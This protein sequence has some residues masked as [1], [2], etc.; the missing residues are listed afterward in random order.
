MHVQFPAQEFLRKISGSHRW[1]YGQGKMIESL[2]KKYN[3][4]L[5]AGASLEDSVR[6]FEIT[7]TKWLERTEG[8]LDFLERQNTQNRFNHARLLERVEALEKKAAG[9]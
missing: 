2:H 4:L 5:E 8:R 6:Q 3:S 1:F 7:V 9:E